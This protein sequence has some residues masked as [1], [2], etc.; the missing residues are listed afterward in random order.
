VLALNANDDHEFPAGGP[1][2]I[3][4]L[5]DVSKNS[6][7]CL[8]TAEADGTNGEAERIETSPSV[9]AFASPAGRRRLY[10]AWGALTD[11]EREVIR[12]RYLASEPLDAPAVARA[13]RVPTRTVQ[14]IERRALRNLRRTLSPWVVLEAA[15]RACQEGAAQPTATGRSTDPSTIDLSKAA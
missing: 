3:A 8:H 14:L 10:G 13:L 1:V 12:R 11:P 5:A 2:Q 7:V 4:W 9:T 15:R 6:V